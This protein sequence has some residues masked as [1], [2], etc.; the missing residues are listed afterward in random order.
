M[1]LVKFAILARKIHRWLLFLTIPLGLAQMTTG[2]VMLYP[3]VFSFI[4]PAVAVPVHLA[5]A[6]WFALFFF[7][8]M[9]TGLFLYLYPWLQRISR[10]NSPQA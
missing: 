10:K 5:T 7:L 2:L 6:P 1:N 8:A 4:T 3:S 9:L